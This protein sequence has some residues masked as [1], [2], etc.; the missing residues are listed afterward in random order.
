MAQ[1]K[2]Q[3]YTL[4]EG[5]EHNVVHTQYNAQSM[6]INKLQDE[7]HMHMQKLFSD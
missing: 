4:Q 6:Q 3:H 2:Q 7:L 1:P 5:V